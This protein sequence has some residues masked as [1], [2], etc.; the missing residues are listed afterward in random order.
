MSSFTDT[1]PS[2]GDLSSPFAPTTVGGLTDDA[3]LSAQ[4]A[5]AE[6]RRRVETQAAV[7][8]A[9]IAHRSRRELGHSGLAAANGQRTPEGLISQ[10]A[11]TSMRDARTLVKAGELQPIAPARATP[12]SGGPSASADSPQRSTMP[13]WLAVIGA[14][15]AAATITIEAADVIRTRLGAAAKRLDAPTA[16]HR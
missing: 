13:R 3:L 14:A 8:T 11:G 15:V 16:P 5:I 1:L 2:L 4:R 10:L 6:V 12:A 9:E 7:V